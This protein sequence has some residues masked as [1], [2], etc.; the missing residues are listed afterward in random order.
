MVYVHCTLWY[1][2][3]Q[4][5]P[6]SANSEFIN[7]IY[8][9]VLAQ[10]A[11]LYFFRTCRIIYIILICYN[12]TIIYIQKRAT[13]YYRWFTYFLGK[14]KTLFYIIYHTT[15]CKLV[16]CYFI[17]FFLILISNRSPLSFENKPFPLLVRNNTK[18]NFLWKP[19][20]PVLSP[21]GYEYQ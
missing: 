19:E 20:N 18:P 12:N 9:F 7:A 21:V 16:L 2:A 13:E 3:A 6:H 15:E 14:I 10:F 17:F 8:R 4:Q 1:I 11:P 5:L